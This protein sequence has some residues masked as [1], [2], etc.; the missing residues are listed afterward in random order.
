MQEYTSGPLISHN[1]AIRWNFWNIYISVR[2]EVLKQSDV[3]EWNRK[4]IVM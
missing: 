3:I 1:S 2:V 4:V